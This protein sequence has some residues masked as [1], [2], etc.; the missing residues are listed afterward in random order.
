MHMTGTGA[1]VF[2]LRGVPAAD[3]LDVWQPSGAGYD[4]TLTFRL[5]EPWG[6]WVRRL[7]STGVA[8]RIGRDLAPRRI[9]RPPGCGLS[10]SFPRLRPRLARRGLRSP[11]LAVTDGAP[12]LVLA[13]QQLW[14]DADRQRCTVHYADLRIMP[15]T[16]L[17]RT[18]LALKRSA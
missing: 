16:G 7:G 18:R 4:I 5:N 1:D 9:P 14:P 3:I 15:T 11:W 6:V 17:P 10:G 12:G 13:A 2:L 8:Q